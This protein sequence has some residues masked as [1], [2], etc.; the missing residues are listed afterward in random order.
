RGNFQSP[1][2][3]PDSFAHPAESNSRTFSAGD[4]ALYIG[5]NS[6]A[7]IAHRQS[8]VMRRTLHRYERRKTAGMAMNIGQT[9]LND[10]KERQSKIAR[11]SVAEA[12]RQLQIDGNFAA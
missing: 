10:A 8:Y 2:K 9:F 11:Q 7:L 4:P 5:R 3:L 6:P 12:G 1:A